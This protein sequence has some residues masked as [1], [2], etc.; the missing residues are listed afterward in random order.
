MAKILFDV[1]DESG[2]TVR[3]VGGQLDFIQME[4]KYDIS[5]SDLQDK[6]RME[7]IAFVCWSAAKR[8]KVTT[9]DFDTWLGSAEFETIEEAPSKK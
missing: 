3:V 9:Q 6:P 7:W 5:V 4:R 2:E 8:H 1:T